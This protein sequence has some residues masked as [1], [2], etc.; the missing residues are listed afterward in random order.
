MDVS[1]RVP[2]QIVDAAITKDATFKLEPGTWYDIGV[3]GQV[4]IQYETSPG[5]FA[6]FPD[7]ISTGNHGFVGKTL[8]TG[9]IKAVYTAAGILNA[10][11]SVDPPTLP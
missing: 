3:T 9:R 2:K 8:N 4:L 7:S 1:K 11:P 10:R 6:D 5:E